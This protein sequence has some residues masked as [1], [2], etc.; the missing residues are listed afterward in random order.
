MASGVG[1]SACAGRLQHRNRLEPYQ[2]PVGAYLIGAGR[3]TESR[4]NEAAILPLGIAASAPATD[5]RISRQCG[6]LTC[7]GVEGAQRWCGLLFN[8]GTGTSG[9]P[10]ELISCCRVPHP[11]SPGVGSGLV[12]EF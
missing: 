8:I 9:G 5:T 10:P 12:T 7:A 1:C 11:P 6:G 2:P 4:G 3:R